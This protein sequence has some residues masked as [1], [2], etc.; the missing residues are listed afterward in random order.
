MPYVPY[1]TL[2]YLYLPYLLLSSCHYEVPPTY[3][4]Y[5]GYS[6]V[7]YTSYLDTLSLQHVRVRYLPR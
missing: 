3:Y 5:Q 7:V 2:P 4:Q 6:V 1:L